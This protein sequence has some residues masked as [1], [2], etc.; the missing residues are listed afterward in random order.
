MVTVQETTV[1][2]DNYA[3]HKYIL[4]DDG[5]LAYGYIRSGDKYP[6][7]FR[8]PITIDWRNRTYKVV[9]RT[10]GVEL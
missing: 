3:N 10:K 1:W 2:N 7:L 4:S 8:K 9:V 6:Q 5:R